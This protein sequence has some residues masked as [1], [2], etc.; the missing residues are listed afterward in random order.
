M[1]N[2]EL[3]SDNHNNDHLLSVETTT[4]LEN[5][6]SQETFELV[7]KLIHNKKDVF[8][9]IFEE[10]NDEYLSKRSRNSEN[11]ETES[12]NNSINLNSNGSLLPTSSPIKSNR[13]IGRLQINQLSKILKHCLHT[14]SGFV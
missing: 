1:E 2:S 13:I 4:F 6:N 12:P 11:E 14:I 8:K 7:S 5:M 10:E 9:R 3:P